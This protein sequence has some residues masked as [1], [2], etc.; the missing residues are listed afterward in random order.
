MAL[1]P[2]FTRL[3]AARHHLCSLVAGFV[4]SVG[5]WAGE[6]VELVFG[7]PEA[8]RA[9]RVSAASIEDIP[10]PAS[11]PLG[12]LWKLFVHAYLADGARK[13]PDYRCTGRAPGEE[14]Y[15]CTPGETISRDEALA[16][17]CGLYF[18]PRRL[19]L[20]ATEWR[21][22]WS[23]QG[24][25]VP[26]WLLDLNQLQPATEV[27]VPSL[28]AALAAIDGPSRQATQAALQRV[29]LEPRARPLLSH[30]GNSLRIKTWSWHDAK[31]RRI[32]GFAGWQADG[33]PLWLRGAGTSA[34]VLEQAAPWLAGKLP[35]PIPPE[36]ACVRVHFFTRYDLSEVLTDGRPAQAGPLRGRVEA[37]FGNGQRLIFDS[38]GD[39]SLERAGD[40][41]RIEGRFGLNDYVARV[42]QREASA[43]PAEAARALGVAAR[44]YLVRHAGH[45]GGC[46]EMD[47]DSRS[48]RVSPAP[49]GNSALA[50]ARWSDGLVLSGVSG[51]YHLTKGGPQQLAWKDAVVWAT[52]G[53]SWDGILK[54]AYGAAGFSVVGESDAGECH[55]LVAAED[56][57]TGRQ[58][59]W[60]R[61]LAGLP[62]FEVPSPP[63]RV[64]RL[65]HGNPYA[66]IERGRI[67]ATGI[68]SSNE[69][70]TLAHEYLHFALALHPRGR[71]EDF[72]ERTARALLGMP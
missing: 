19:A 63:P 40:R 51:R 15:C 65:A 71:D 6:S 54:R 4:L 8:P 66:D 42:I 52:E 56:W 28:L 24:A 59:A 72:V 13:I 31:G 46:Y 43:H 27:S 26:A 68:G 39:L 12:S 25:G 64:C 58:V 67:Y 21:T 38:I 60:R 3:S 48:Q 49:P 44:T 32:G 45:G 69:R 57:L 36:T 35:Q 17:S 62:G 23:R 14:A 37:R 47:D 1:R 34:Q 29:S 70:L 9:L 33:M 10:V 22:Y 20:S 55:P 30:L 53:A 5:A 16:K 50:A 11:T 18:V 2:P 7:D 61:Q 41:L